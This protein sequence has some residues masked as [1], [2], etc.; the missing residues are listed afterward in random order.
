MVLGMFTACQPAN[1][2][3]L[4]IYNV[5]DY[6]N[7]D[8]IDIFEKEKIINLMESFCSMDLEAQLLFMLYIEGESGQ[9]YESLNTFLNAYSENV[10]NAVKIL[11]DVEMGA[12]AYNYYVMLHESGDITAEE[13]EAALN[14]MNEAYA[15]FEAA[16]QALTDTELAEFADFENVYEFYKALLADVNSDVEAAA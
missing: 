3:Q 1:R 5:G 4:N 7:E 8:V 10:S 2:T 15:A 14:D 9:Y 6:I 16:Y 13:L 12:I 11:L